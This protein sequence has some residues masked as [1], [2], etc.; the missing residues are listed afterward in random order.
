MNIY[1]TKYC[2]HWFSFTD[3]F[4]YSIAIAIV[5]VNGYL[6]AGYNNMLLSVE[7]IKFEH[8]CFLLCIYAS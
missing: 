6:F 4:I 7:M 5:Y 2:L 1:F 8:L 3:V